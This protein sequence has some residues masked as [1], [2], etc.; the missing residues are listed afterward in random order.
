MSRRKPIQRE[1][2]DSIEELQDVLQKI[3]SEIPHLTCQSKQ[4]PFDFYH[5]YKKRIKNSFCKICEK[6]SQNLSKYWMKIHLVRVGTL[7][8]NTFKF[9]RWNFLKKSI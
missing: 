8:R 4:Y 1:K 6:K 5:I 2:L 3:E 7:K 9:I